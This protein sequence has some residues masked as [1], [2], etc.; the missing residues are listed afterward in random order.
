MCFHDNVYSKFGVHI[1][2]EKQ[3]Q[4]PQR[5]R[6]EAAWRWWRW[7]QWNKFSDQA[8]SLTVTEEQNFVAKTTSISANSRELG[9]LA[10]LARPHSLWFPAPNCS[11]RAATLEVGSRS[12]A[13]AYV[14]ATDEEAGGR[15]RSYTGT[16]RSFSL[17]ETNG[18]SGLF[19]NGR[20]VGETDSTAAAA[21]AGE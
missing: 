18:P 4:H 12:C 7:W 14:G 17:T 16:W 10:S 1:E 21:R 6:E 3:H 11:S 20:G 2:I 15:G 13:V 19:G 8:P 5:K 9:F